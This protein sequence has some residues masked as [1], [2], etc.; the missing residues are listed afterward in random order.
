MIGPKSVIPGERERRVARDIPGRD[1]LTILNTRRPLNIVFTARDKEKES[2]PIGVNQ[3]GRFSAFCGPSSVNESTTVT[4]REPMTLPV[5]TVCQGPGR[6]A[7][8]EGYGLRWKLENTKKAEAVQ[9][10]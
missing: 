8:E 5:Q 3:G 6:I 10:D 2:M 7:K 9:A 1:V 4:A